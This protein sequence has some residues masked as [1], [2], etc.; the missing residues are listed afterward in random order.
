MRHPY[1][2]LPA[3]MRR[4]ASAAPGGSGAGASGAGPSRAEEAV[5]RSDGNSGEAE[6]CQRGSPRRR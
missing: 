3:L 5:S 1:S 6:G 4:G 2:F